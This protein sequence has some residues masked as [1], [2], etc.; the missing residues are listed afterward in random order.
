MHV[1]VQP[2]SVTIDLRPYFYPNTVNLQDATGTLKAAILS[3][4]TFDATNVNPNTVEIAGAP[5]FV[6]WWE[7]ISGDGRY[8]FL[9]KVYI[10]QVNLNGSITST[11]VSGSTYDGVYFLGIDSIEIVP[12]P[13]PTTNWS[14][15]YP[16]LYWSA[17]S[18]AVCYQVEIDND[19]DFSSPEQVATNV[20]GYYYNV[21]ALPNGT[22]YWRVRVGGVCVGVLQSGWSASRTFTVP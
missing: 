9:S 13:A 8:D 22:Y 14:S 7:D 17:T 15:T 5:I 4:N 20:E 6:S 19:S 3:T 12:P 16:T 21:D 2:I 11:G 10:S 1:T 18:G